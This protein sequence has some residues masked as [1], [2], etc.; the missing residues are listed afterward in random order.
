MGCIIGSKK[1]YVQYLTNQLETWSFGVPHIMVD[2]TK[3]SKVIV[4]GVV[5]K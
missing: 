2:L 3:P 1:Y 4:H 5:L